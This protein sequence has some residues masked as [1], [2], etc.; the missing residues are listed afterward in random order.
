MTQTVTYFLHQKHLLLSIECRRQERTCK[1]YKIQSNVSSQH[2]LRQ[3]LISD[4]R[5]IWSKYIISCSTIC[6]GLSYKQIRKLALGCTKLLVRP[7]P[8]N[9]QNQEM[10]A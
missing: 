8:Q 7:T 6:Y 5:N 2:A 4:K 9:W 1:I 3:S 10:Q